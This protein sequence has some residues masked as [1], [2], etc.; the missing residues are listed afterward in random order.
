VINQKALI[1]GESLQSAS[2]R[3]HRCSCHRSFCSSNKAP[4]AQATPRE[5]PWLPARQGLVGSAPRLKKPENSEALSAGTDLHARLALAHE[6]Y[7]R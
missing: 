6:N 5:A 7:A 1:V 2:C 3:E 4:L